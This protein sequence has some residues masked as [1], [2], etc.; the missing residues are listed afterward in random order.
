MQHRV[1]PSALPMLPRLPQGPNLQRATLTW[2]SPAG[3][4]RQRTSA[5]SSEAATASSGDARS[6]TASCGWR[7][8]S[9][10]SSSVVRA[11]SDPPVGLRHSAGPMTAAA[12]TL[13]PL[14]VGYSQ[15][16]RFG[17]EVKP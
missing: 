5:H 9:R 14:T 4:T 15:A 16:L 3:W 11:R 2:T 8:T 6:K 12:T 13:R 7:P 17:C 1:V 10:A